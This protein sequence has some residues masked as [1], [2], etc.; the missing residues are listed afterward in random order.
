M[1]KNACVKY[2]AKI[3][4]INR[5]NLSFFLLLCKRIWLIGIVV[6]SYQA[7][8]PISQIYKLYQHVRF[9]QD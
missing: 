7:F 1:S 3:N 6:I 4:R 9:M 8:Y 2:C 5:T